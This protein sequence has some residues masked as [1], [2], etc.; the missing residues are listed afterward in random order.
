MT[1]ADGS[2]LDCSHFVR[3]PAPQVDKPAL[4]VDRATFTPEELRI[5]GIAFEQDELFFIDPKSEVAQ[6]DSREAA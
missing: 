6:G 2:L 1:R 4:L 3:E 5:M